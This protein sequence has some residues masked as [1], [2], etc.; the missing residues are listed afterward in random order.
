V[1]DAS[2]GIQAKLLRA[3]EEST[4]RPVGSNASRR[5]DVR[6]V[7]ATNCDLRAIVCEGRFRHDLYYRLHVL[8]I[9]VPPLRERC[10]DVRLL[11]L[12]FLR[13]LSAQERTRVAGFSPG[14]LRRLETYAWPGN[15]RELRSE[16]HR[17]VM[18]A[19]DGEWITP[20]QLAEQIADGGGDSAED[21]LRP[22]REIVREVEAATIRRRLRHFGYHRAATARSLGVTR[23][24]LWVK[25]RRS[26]SGPASGPR[27]QLVTTRMEKRW[28]VPA[29]GRKLYLTCITTVVQRTV[30]HEFRVPPRAR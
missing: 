4:V 13:E 24:W 23:E 15:V 6:L 3:L 5:I 17:L 28:R 7:A 1:S 14:A 26:A 2:P 16:I 30:E 9:V 29:R 19:D 18:W 21:G 20:D 8:P 27:R 25:M 22:L 12:H 11:A 10:G